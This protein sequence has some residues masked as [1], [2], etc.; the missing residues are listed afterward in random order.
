M[1][2]ATAGTSF[3]GGATSSTAPNAR[4]PS[5]VVKRR[6]YDA[7]VR[8]LEARVAELEME[9][10]EQAR[11]IEYLRRV[12]EDYEAAGGV[13]SAA[14]QGQGQGQGHQQQGGARKQPSQV[15]VGMY[16]AAGGAMP[17]QMQYEANN[18][19][20]YSQMVGEISFALLHYIEYKL[21]QHEADQRV[22]VPYTPLDTRDPVDNR[23]AEFYNSTGSAVP[24]VRINKGFYKYGHSLV[25]LEIVNHKL[26]AKT[27]DGWNRGKF[28]AIEKF[29]SAYEP[30]ERDRLGLSVEE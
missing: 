26:M 17:T 25:E 1:R 5:S 30:L 18:S 27:E 29:M 7:D 15:H 8:R 10:G 2:A 16:G 14:S 4:E 19:S 13:V 28:G 24:F 9:N 23:L 20:R 11:E 12:V 6:N 3:S 22:K 21:A